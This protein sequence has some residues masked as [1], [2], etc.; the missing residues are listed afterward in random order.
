MKKIE[1]KSY[2]R[3]DSQVPFPRRAVLPRAGRPS[4]RAGQGA[5]SRWGEWCRSSAQVRWARRDWRQQII[6]M[7]F[8]K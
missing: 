3:A 8:K 6:K 1:H 7:K 4:G 5:P 2:I